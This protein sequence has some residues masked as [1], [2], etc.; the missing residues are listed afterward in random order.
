MAYILMQQGED[1]FIRTTLAGVAC[2]V[3]I[4]AGGSNWGL[5]LATTAVGTNT[6]ANKERVLN[7]ASGVGKIQ[8]IGQATA[9]G[10]ARA[11]IP[12]NATGW[13][14]PTGHPGASYSTTSPQKSFSFSGA[15]SANGAAS[16]WLC[17]TT[18][19][20]G[21][22]AVDDVMFG[23]DLAAIR[24]FASGDTENITITYQQT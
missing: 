1:A 6:V 18:V 21:T 24:N 14:N 7:T 17:K 13:P 12:R 15:P 5:A 16:W 11:S 23:A 19:G 9:N 8:E 10:Y 22:S 2:A 20:I 3:A 4:P